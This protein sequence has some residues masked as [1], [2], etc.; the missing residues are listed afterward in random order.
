[1]VGRSRRRKAGSQ[2]DDGV[3]SPCNNVCQIDT[4]KA[5]CRGCWRTLDEIAAWSSAD[6]DEKRAI[7]QRIRQRAMAIK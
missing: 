4:E 7:W 2:I 1:M 3:R 5:Q 6:D